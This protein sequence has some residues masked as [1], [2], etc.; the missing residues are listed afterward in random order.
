MVDPKTNEITDRRVMALL[1]GGGYADFAKVNKD[2]IIDVPPSVSFEQA[3]AIPEAFITAYQ[4]LH[5]IAHIKEG[6][7]A[8]ILAGASGVGT[9]MIQLCNLAGASAVAVSS[10]HAKLE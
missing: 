2:H 7:T 3:A 10:S 4:L 5:T 8:L 9:S 6:E 1:S